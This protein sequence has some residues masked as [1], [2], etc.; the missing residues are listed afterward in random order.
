MIKNLF[1]ELPDSDLLCCYKEWDVLQ[2]KTGVRAPGMFDT[3]IDKYDSM[4]EEM[5]S[6]YPLGCVHLAGEHLHE[7]IAKR[8]ASI[9]EETTLLSN[10]LSELHNQQEELYRGTRK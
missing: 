9:V 2:H 3:I 4:L 5:G 10:R 7:E 8:W 1:G 6:N